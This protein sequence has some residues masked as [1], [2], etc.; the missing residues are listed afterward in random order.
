VVNRHE[1][2]LPRACLAFFKKHLPRGSDIRDDDEFG[3][4]PFL[5]DPDRVAQMVEEFLLKLE[6]RASAA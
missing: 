6:Q 2:I 4:V 5:D 3:H 1:R